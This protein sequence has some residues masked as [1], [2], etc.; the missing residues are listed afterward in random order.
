[1]LPLWIWAWA[2][3]QFSFATLI[4]YY[5]VTFH[6]ETAHLVRLDSWLHQ[7]RDTLNPNS[8][9][10]LRLVPIYKAIYLL[11]FGI[12]GLIQLGKLQN[13]DI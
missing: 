10:N 6:I 7:V 8:L 4:C 11:P 9:L 12:M 3:P 5:T 13:S 1:M 2:D